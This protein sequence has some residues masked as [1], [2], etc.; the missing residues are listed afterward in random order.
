L[1]HPVSH[2]AGITF[3]SATS[4]A[5][6][7][8][9]LLDRDELLPGDE[10]WAQV[11]LQQP[12]AVV[13]GDHCVLRTSNDTVGGGPILQVNPPRR[14]R[15]HPATLDLLRR[16]AEGSIETRVLDELLPGPAELAVLASRL[17]VEPGQLQTAIEALAESGDLYVHGRTLVGARWLDL[18]VSRITGE[19]SQFLTANA[20]RDNAPREHVRRATGLSASDFDLAVHETVVR[21]ELREEGAG[22]APPGYA[23]ALPSEHKPQ[24]D[25]FLTALREGGYSPPTDALPPPEIVAF[26]ASR[27]LV[28]PT[29][30]G[31][32]FDAVVYQEMV[33]RVRRFIEEQG[34]VSLAQTRDLFGTSRKYAQAFLEHLDEQRITRR[35][36]DERVLRSR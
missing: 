36:G 34:S 35:V 20:L 28:E 31:V 16:K 7:Q 19:T 11:V 8:L 12:V 21:G 10:A 23:A 15:N 33:Q 29:R 26:L 24:V 30:G 1:P 13:P 3:L 32:V 2:A 18:A 6:G 5:Q 25:A 9:R 22:L 27:G 14:R 4:E 17:T